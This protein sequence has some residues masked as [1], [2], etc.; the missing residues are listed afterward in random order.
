MKP[1]VVGHEEVRK[2]ELDGYHMWKDG[3]GGYF[4]NR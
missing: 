1:V 4:G 3:G 2:E